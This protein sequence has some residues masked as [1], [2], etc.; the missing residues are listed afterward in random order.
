MATASTIRPG[1]AYGAY[2]FA[3]QCHLELNITLHIM[4]SRGAALQ[5]EVK[6]ACE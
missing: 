6:S 1:G 3:T 4:I 2:G 5:V